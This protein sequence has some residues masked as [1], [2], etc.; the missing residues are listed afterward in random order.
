MRQL[1]H[2]RLIY[3]GDTLRCPY[4]PRPEHEVR[5]FT[6]QMAR[7]L[8]KKNI[9]MLVIA[10]N[11]A[12][13]FA[14]TDLQ[15]KLDIP[16]IGVIQPGSRT[17][18]KSTTTNHVGVIG[19]EGTIRSQAYHITLQQIKPELTVRCVMQP[20]S[21]TDIK[22]TTTNHVGV[23]GTEGTIR[24]QAY[25]NTLKQ[26]KPEISV[27]ALA[28]PTF[29]P[30]VEQGILSG[31]YANRVVKHALKPLM[32]NHSMDTLILGCTHYPL[33]KNVIQNVM[34]EHIAIISSSEETARE[35]ST[36]LEVHQ[37]A[38]KNVSKP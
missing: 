11:T 31:Q 9:K 28:C 32:E 20:G 13:A 27:Q 19:T 17:A 6:W 16:V 29:V 5:Q 22:S 35:T 37:L 25:H 1:P 10:C 2:E 8:L 24:S 3:L 34:G 12:T 36:I 18:I 21:R 23:I 26:I 30:L 33:L 15:K 7:F 4:G 38:A 14:L